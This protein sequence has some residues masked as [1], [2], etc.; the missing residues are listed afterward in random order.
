MLEGSLGPQGDLDRLFAE[1]VSGEAVVAFRDVQDP[2]VDLRRDFPSGSN[3]VT[4]GEQKKQERKI[5]VLPASGEPR[6]REFL[7]FSRNL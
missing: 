3:I 4:F 7:G 6:E 2:D 1:L 5:R